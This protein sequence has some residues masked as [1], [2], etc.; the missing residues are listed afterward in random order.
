MWNVECGSVS[1]FVYYTESKKIQVDILMLFT[2]EHAM[3]R[4]SSN[5]KLSAT[6]SMLRY[7]ESRPCLCILGLVFILYGLLY[8]RRMFH[9]SN[10][11]K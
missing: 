9:K 1:V 7:I 5:E 3:H 8:V 2:M 11:D 4:S 6:D 10:H